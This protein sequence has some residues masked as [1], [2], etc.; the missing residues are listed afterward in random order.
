VQKYLTL[1]GHVYDP[2]ILFISTDDF[3][4]LAADDKTTFVAAAKLAGTASRQFSETAEKNGVAQLAQSG[5][6]VVAD[7]DRQQFA[8]SMASAN[9]VFAKEFGG[10]LIERIKQYQ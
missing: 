6:Q 3:D 9:P 4:A 8:A 1:S 5:M 7:V 2:A 10:D